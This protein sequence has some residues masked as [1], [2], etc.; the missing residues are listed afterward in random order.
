MSDKKRIICDGCKFEKADGE[1]WIEMVVFPNTRT[2]I[3]RTLFDYL[4]L[5]FCS[6]EC[7]SKFALDGG[8]E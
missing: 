1:K 7:I 4:T 3:K 2:L 6:R 8:F 5:D